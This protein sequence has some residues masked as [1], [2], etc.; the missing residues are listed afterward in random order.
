MART[1][2]GSRWLRWLA[3]GLG[4]L[5]VLF[6][7]AMAVSVLLARSALL[8]GAA[9]LRHAQA[10][11]TSAQVERAPLR[12]IDRVSPAL[13]Q[14]RADFTR[15]D[16]RLAPFSPVL[17]R[18]GWLPAIGRDLAASPL[19][20]QLGKETTVGAST[21]VATV[22]PVLAGDPG[23]RLTVQALLHRI[24]A[25]RPHIGGACSSFAAATATRAQIGAHPSPRLAGPLRTVDRTLPNLLTFCRALVAL[26]GLLG[27]NGPASYLIAYQNPTQIRAQGGFLGSAALLTVR[28]G[29]VSQQ[30]VG[31]WLQ[32]K[33]TYA[34]PLAMGQEDGEPAWL[35]RD[36]NWSPDFPTSAALERFF[37][38]LDL[39]WKV[40]GVINIT[41]QAVA[42][43]LKAL[44][45]VYVPEY[46]RRVD[47]ANVAALADFYAHRTDLSGP[48]HT[49]SADTQRKQFIGIVAQHL[50]ARL[51][52][53][54]PETILRL[55]RDL[56]HAIRTRDL[57][58]NFT[59]AQDQRLVQRIGAAGGVNPTGA[60][61][62]DV[63]DS[64]ISY[65]K[66]NAYVRES[67]SY[68]ATVMPTRWVQGDLMITYTNRPAPAY[69][70][71]D[72][73]G[74]GAG[75]TGT[76]ADYGDF[77]R[78]LV[79]AGAQL[80][81]QSGW[82]HPYPAGPAYG[83]TMFSG[84]LIVRK[85][86]TRSVHLRYLMP[87]N[88]FEQT[89]GRTYRFLLQHQPGTHPVSAEVAVTADGTTRSWAVS[90]PDTDWSV[91]A[92]I[93]DRPFSP[94]SLPANPLPVVKPGHWLEPG[95][96][97]GPRQ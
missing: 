21:L 79:P 94:I 37:A 33:L 93:Q 65:N 40:N 30:F 84:Y 91:S 19:A 48:L 11:L 2:R 28:N 50:F 31:T 32:D 68:H 43:A 88:I 47:A 75:R 77:V 78:V 46:R 95:T 76:P 81:S 49:G 18:L 35:F 25:A 24:D 80:L 26:P 41:P 36:S 89:A 59:D 29:N 96:F 13:A 73:F 16:D 8:D 52:A 45:P 83:K 23:G 92:P 10:G 55:A 58:I 1:R 5:V 20:A 4:I 42:A 61:Y 90:H 63:V 87:P 12:A 67:F 57:L 85:G 69:I 72:G 70:Y 82:L 86:T 44:G 27:A 17:R 54:S 3:A 97:L 60:D 7:S 14:A 39:G 22:R 38:R 62:L 53:L 51:H 9:E 34:P 64:N 74:P 6:F 56:G 15:A 66:I 71:K